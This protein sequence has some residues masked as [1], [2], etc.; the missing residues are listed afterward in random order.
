MFEK[1]IQSIPVVSPSNGIVI[2]ILNILFPGLG[3]M[4]LACMSSNING[5]QLLIGMLQFLTFIFLFVGILWAI[6]WSIMVLQKTGQPPEIVIIPS[7]NIS[8]RGYPYNPITNSQSN[9]NQNTKQAKELDP[10]QSQNQFDKINNFQ[11]QN[12]MADKLNDAHQQ[13]NN[14]FQSREPAIV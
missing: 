14:I 13:K 12:N 11:S 9:V 7:P 6:W 8:V 3:T 10:S 1:W 4:I 2:L 5:E